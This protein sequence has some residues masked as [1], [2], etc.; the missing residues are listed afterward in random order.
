[1]VWSAGGRREFVRVKRSA[2]TGGLQSGFLT[3]CEP[4]WKQ[5]LERYVVRPGGFWLTLFERTWGLVRRSAMGN[6]GSYVRS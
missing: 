3:T 1:M 4:N 5:P 6:D 2:N